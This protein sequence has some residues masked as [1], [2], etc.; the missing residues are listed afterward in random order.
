[1]GVFNKNNTQD[2][3]EWA[4][5]YVST[6]RHYHLSTVFWDNGVLDVTACGEII[7]ELHRD[8][9]K[10]ILQRLINTYI[11]ASKIEFYDLEGFPVDLEDNFSR[12]GL[13]VDKDISIF[14]G[15]IT[16][17]KLID[18]MGLCCNLGNIL[19]VFDTAIKGNS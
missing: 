1:M 8:E 17:D 19:D 16:T 10:Q 3:I 9:L 14:D 2:R 15:K 7:G 11:K 13:V 18:S 6:A 4:E 5:Y 12:E